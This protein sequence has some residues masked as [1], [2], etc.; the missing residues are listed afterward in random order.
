M[1][2]HIVVAFEPERRAGGG[3]HHAH[4]FDDRFVLA[5]PQDLKINY[6]FQ[7]C[8]TTNDGIFEII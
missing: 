4:L 1:I 3:A 5:S 6:S 2:S 8:W 7:P